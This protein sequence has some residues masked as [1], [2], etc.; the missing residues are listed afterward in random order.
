MIKVTE[1][2]LDE[3]MKSCSVVPIPALG[4]GSGLWGT[5]RIKCSNDLLSLPLAMSF[6]FDIGPL[7]LGPLKKR[8]S[9]IALAL[10]FVIR[11][12][13]LGEA[14]LVRRNLVSGRGRWAHGKL[15]SESDGAAG[16]E[17]VF[18]D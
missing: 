9:V 15:P 7:S 18:A 17:W 12:A 10:K 16:V 11:D 6:E 1:H 5:S 2:L 4:V 13:G 3:P 14:P 8:H